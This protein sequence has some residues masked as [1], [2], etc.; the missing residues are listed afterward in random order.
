V[1]DTLLVLEFSRFLP[2]GIPFRNQQSLARR[3]NL[4]SKRSVPPGL[5]A[6]D[7]KVPDTTSKTDPR[8]EAPEGGSLMGPSV[9]ELM[10]VSWK[11]LEMLLAPQEVNH[12]PV[13]ES[14]GIEDPGF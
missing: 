14:W 9:L 3:K 13:L 2:P 8:G 6:F 5:A 7:P 10:V 12:L 1:G 4:N 11:P